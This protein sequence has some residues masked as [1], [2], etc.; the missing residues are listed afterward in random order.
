MFRVKVCGITSVADAQS[1]ADAGAD[2]I[3]FNFFPLSPRYI[4][5]R[6]AR[7]IVEVLSPGVLKV[8]VFVNSPIAEIRAAIELLH[9]DLVQLHGD[10]EPEF[11]A[12]LEG[13]PV[14]RA[15]RVEAGLAGLKDYLSRCQKLACLPRMVL[16][17]AYKKGAY[18]GTGETTDW[19]L[20]SGERKEVRELPLVLAGGLTP[21]NVA[22]AIATVRPAAVD[23][24]SGVELRP[25][26]KSPQLMQAFVSA[27]KQAFADLG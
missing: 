5:L 17:D 15:F 4:E 8:G 11:I 22:A 14:M 23:T 20:L 3:G 9:L 24:A 10:E 18:G 7:Q 16:V 25:G 26:Q 6:R 27:A 2:A 19:K 13:R 12:K 1:A 21:R